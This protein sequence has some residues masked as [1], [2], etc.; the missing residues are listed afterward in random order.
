MYNDSTPI[1]GKV[2]SGIGALIDA[3][4]KFPQEWALTPCIGKKKPL[5]GLAEDKT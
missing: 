4:N 1:G 3:I 2:S 5:A